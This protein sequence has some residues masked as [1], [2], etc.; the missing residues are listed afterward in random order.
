VKNYGVLYSR[1]IPL[2]FTVVTCMSVCHIHAL[3]SAWNECSVLP[4]M[5]QYHTVQRF[6]AISP[7]SLSPSVFEMGLS[8]PSFHKITEEMSDLFPL[9][10]GQVLIL[11]NRVPLPPPQTPPHPEPKSWP[12]SCQLLSI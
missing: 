12:V 7:I 4:P 1:P 11:P 3:Y 2:C 6:T 8:L 9:V 5:P 10:T